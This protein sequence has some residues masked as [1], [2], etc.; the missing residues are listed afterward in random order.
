MGHDERQRVS[1]GESFR[2]GIWDA[3]VMTSS[4]EAPTAHA[5]PGD[6]ANGAGCTRSRADEEPLRAVGGRRCS[7]TAASASMFLLLP[8]EPRLPLRRLHVRDLALVITHVCSHEATRDPSGCKLFFLGCHPTRAS[9]V[10][11]ERG[12]NQVC[13]SPRVWPVGPRSFF[14]EMLGLNSSDRF[15]QKKA[16]HSPKSP[17]KLAA[18]MCACARC[19][20]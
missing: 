19:D 11:A 3:L 7:A 2:P 12:G 13:H 14:R 10:L 15:R 4:T 9:R 20:G 18:G 17:E 6:V 1:G 8:S 16:V 5:A